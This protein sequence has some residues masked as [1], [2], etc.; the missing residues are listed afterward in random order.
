MTVKQVE[1]KITDLEVRRPALV[2]AQAKADTE[3]TKIEEER[4]ALVC[5]ARVEGDRAAQKKLTDLDA[6]WAL[7]TREAADA[8]TA[9]EYV[10]AALRD[11]AKAKQKAARRQMEV[12]HCDAVVKMQ[13]K[14]P[15]LDAL[16]PPLLDKMQEWVDLCLQEYDL[17]HKLGYGTLRTPRRQLAD[18][19]LTYFKALCGPVLERPTMTMRTPDGGPANFFAQMSGRER[20]PDPEDNGQASDKGGT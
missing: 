13:V 1:Q 9:L 12:A 10:D 3:L 6:Q 18:V 16:M 4:K 14:A 8:R 19:L 17:R 11:L 2:E 5:A 7:A 20:R 15:E